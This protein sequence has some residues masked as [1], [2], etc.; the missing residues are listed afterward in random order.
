M[1]VADIACAGRDTFGMELGIL[2]E[3][4]VEFAVLSAKD[5]ATMAT[6]VTTAEEVE[7][8]AAGGRVAVG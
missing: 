8:S 6:V 7:E 2:V 1:T 3:G 5:V 4:N